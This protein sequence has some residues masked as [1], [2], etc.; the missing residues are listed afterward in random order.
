M[1]HFRAQLQWVS[2]AEEDL[3]TV[4][5]DSELHESDLAAGIIL[6]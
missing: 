6:G 3:F 1:G 4:D 2:G 5:Y